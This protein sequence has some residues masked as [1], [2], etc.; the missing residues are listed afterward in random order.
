LLNRFLGEFENHSWQGA[1]SAVS[2]CESPEES[3]LVNSLLFEPP[4]IE[5]PV[6]VANEALRMIHHRHLRRKLQE[7]AL[8]IARKASISPDESF[9][10]LKRDNELKQAMQRPPQILPV[11]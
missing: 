9:Q 8:E 3:A 5:D 6:K 1:G 7:I 11:Q 10:L 4:R 2:L